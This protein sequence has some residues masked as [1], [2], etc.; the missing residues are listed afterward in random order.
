MNPNTVLNL[1]LELDNDIRRNSDYPPPKAIY[2][3]FNFM[4]YI[5]WVFTC[6]AFWLLYIE[7]GI[8]LKDRKHD[9]WKYGL[10]IIRFE[11]QLSPLLDM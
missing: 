6:D 2:I 5:N 3:S 11:F 7:I 1:E 10:S 9:G 8:L 4:E